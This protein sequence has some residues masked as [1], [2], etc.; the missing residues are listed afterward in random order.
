MSLKTIGA[1][2]LL[3]GEGQLEKLST[4]RAGCLPESRWNRNETVQFI[5]SIVYTEGSIKEADKAAD[6]KLARKSM[7]A[8][9][10]WLTANLELKNLK[11]TI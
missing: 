7:A 8:E 2:F 6:R 4:V 1:R 3:C 9:E 10:K 5:L 11:H